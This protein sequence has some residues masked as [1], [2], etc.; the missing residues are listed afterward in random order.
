MKIDFVFV[1]KLDHLY[2]L[3]MSINYLIRNYNNCNIFIITNK[4]NFTFFKCI[5]QERI[6]LIDEKELLP[7]MTLKDLKKIKLPYFPKRAGWYYQQF[8]KLAVSKLH[9]IS[10]NY[11][12]LDAD[13]IILKKINFIE[14]NKFI[15]LKA[16]EYNESYFINYQNLL[17]EDPNR[18]FSFISQCMI[19]NKKLVHELL[20]KITS[21][22]NNSESWNWIIVNNLIGT[23]ASLFSEYETYGHYLKNHYK[24]KCNFINL[25]WIRN[26][27]ILIGTM[28]PNFKQLENLKNNYFLVSFE[29]Q[30]TRFLPKIYKHTI[31]KTYP[32][33][34]KFKSIFFAK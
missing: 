7:D 17:N 32:Y 9:Y 22:F 34:F 31:C 30:E 26:G 21:R 28:F 13:T 4:L 33:F 2:T 27:S 10:E 14:N 20:N 5:K 3:D 8:L 11:V 19:F 29:H 16:T 1:T 23:G 15:F 6:F 24:E 18:E 25:S 12:V